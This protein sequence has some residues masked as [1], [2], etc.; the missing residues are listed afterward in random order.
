MLEADFAPLARGIA[1]CEAHFHRRETPL[2]AMERRFAGKD[3]IVKLVDHFAS[4]NLGAGNRLEVPS[5]VAVDRDPFW[6]RAQIG[7]IAG[8]DHE[9]EM[10]MEP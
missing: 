2:A 7:A 9:A 10:L 4:R 3:R 5:I 1:D 6:S 8:C